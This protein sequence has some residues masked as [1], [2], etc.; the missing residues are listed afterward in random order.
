MSISSM[1]SSTDSSFLAGMPECLVPAIFSSSFSLI[2]SISFEAPCN[3]LLGVSPLLAD[4]AAPAAFC[5][6]SDSAF[7]SIDSLLFFFLAIA[8]AAC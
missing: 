2:S 8:I 4:R 3:S 6:A 1:S 5:C 7:S